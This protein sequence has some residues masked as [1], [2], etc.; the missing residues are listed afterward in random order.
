MKE[1]DFGVTSKPV[2]KLT[3]GY[4]FPQGGGQPEIA[5]DETSCVFNSESE[6]IFEKNKLLRICTNNEVILEDNSLEATYCIDSYKPRGGS[7]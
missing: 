5:C 3:W 1:A 2:M 4:Y 7:E 6:R